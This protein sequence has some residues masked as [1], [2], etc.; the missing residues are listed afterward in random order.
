MKW[1]QWVLLLIV[2]GACKDKYVA[3]VHVPATGF[4]V[5]EG[6]INAS[7]TTD[8]MLSRTSGLDSVRLIP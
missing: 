3:D 2:L 7:D 1:R 5:V 8:I 4:L 6:Y